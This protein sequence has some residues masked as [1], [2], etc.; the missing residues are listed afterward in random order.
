MIVSRKME[1]GNSKRDD[2]KK[3]LIGELLIKYKLITEED[4]KKGLSHQ[5][6]TS[7][8]LGEA[9]VKLGKASPHDIEWVLSKQLDIPYVIVDGSSIDIELIGKFPKDLLTDY[10]LL[11]LFETDSELVVATDDPYN[12]E[13][14]RSL[15]SHAKKQ[16]RV[17]TGNRGKIEEV[18][19]K[20]FMKEGIPEL[21]S[22][23]E[24]IFEKLQETSFYRIDFILGKSEFSIN[25]FGFG[26]LK[27]I[28]KIGVAYSRDDVFSALCHLNVPFFYEEHHND[29]WTFLS[30]FPLKGKL[31]VPELPAILGSFGLGIPEDTAFSNMRAV[32][33]PN[34]FFSERPVT[35]YR[36]ICMKKPCYEYADSVYTA[37][38]APEG[39]SSFFVRAS[40]PETCSSCG[41]GGCGDC[42]GLGYLFKKVE[43]IHSSADLKK[44]FN[45]E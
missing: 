31:D 27:T 22:R 38:S 7:L 13:A 4:L 34:L 9:L 41:G 30:I 17:S 12:T 19:A 2:G 29:A 35:G 10:R 33:V 18:L 20:A 28:E 8:R 24:S 44:H 23:I 43:G 15:E 26:I 45:R 40:V 6:E 5:K 14:L 3:A 11:P 37:D 16:V 36:Y 21:V 32:G 1:N 25:V 42:A 39:F